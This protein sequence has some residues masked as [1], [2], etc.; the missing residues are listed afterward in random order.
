MKLGVVSKPVNSGRRS[1]DVPAG[2]EIELG[3]RAFKHYGGPASFV[4][5]GE[6]EGLVLEVPANRH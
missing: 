2:Q 1:T 6:D 3:H 4:L 5:R